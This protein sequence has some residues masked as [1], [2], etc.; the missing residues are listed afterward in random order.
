MRVSLMDPDGIRTIPGHD[1]EA[2]ALASRSSGVRYGT[3]H[4]MLVGGHV[5]LTVKLPHVHPAICIDWASL[6]G[7]RHGL[8]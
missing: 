1:L 5:D 6:Q 4:L 7:S 8:G 3:P 2:R